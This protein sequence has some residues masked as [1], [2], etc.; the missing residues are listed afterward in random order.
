MIA[1]MT[2]EV[3]AGV[4]ALHRAVQR[5]RAAAGVDVPDAEVTVPGPVGGRLRRS[6][7][8][9]AGHL[10]WVDWGSIGRIGVWVD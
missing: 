9:A 10:L 1:V 4:A 5:R 6:A 2:M 7:R 3:V 8:G